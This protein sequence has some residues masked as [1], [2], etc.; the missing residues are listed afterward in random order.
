MPSEMDPETVATIRGLATG[1]RSVIEGL[2]GR[3]SENLEESDL[4]PCSYVLVRLA[5][6]VALSAPEA[7]FRTLVGV[8]SD[9]GVGAERLLGAMIAVA[10]LVGTTRL[11]AASRELLHALELDG[12]S[13]LAG[14]A[15]PPRRATCPETTL[16]AELPACQGAGSAAARRR[17]QPQEAR[18][19]WTAPGRC[20]A[21]WTRLG[22]PVL[23]QVP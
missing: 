16:R 15:P 13:R 17:A 1:E 20:W 6:L 23:D 4:D 22:C 9:M 21:P 2:L 12:T 10:P 11:I 14:G 19:A 18:G 8:A 5:A 3:Q 7:E